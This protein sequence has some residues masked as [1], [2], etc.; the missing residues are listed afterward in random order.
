MV[1]S[2]MDKEAKEAIGNTLIEVHAHT[3]TSLFL[4]PVLDCPP[5]PPR[6]NSFGATNAQEYTGNEER[7]C[8]VCLVLMCGSAEDTC[9]QVR[10]EGEGELF[11]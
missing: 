6:T 4:M 3:H 11:N 10:V 9:K 2:L 8:E 1:Q 7:G 5:P